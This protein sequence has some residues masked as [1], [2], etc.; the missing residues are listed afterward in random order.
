MKSV[1]KVL[2]AIVLAYAGLMLA[3]V[4]GGFLAGALGAF[5]HL[6]LRTVASFEWTFPKVIFVGVLVWLYLREKR[7]RLWPKKDMKS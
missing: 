1:G 4:V 5:F 7:K 2:L 3:S 6:S